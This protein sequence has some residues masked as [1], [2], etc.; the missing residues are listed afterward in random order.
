[1]RIVLL[2]APGVGKGTQARVIAEAHRIPAVATGDILRAAMRDETPLG[3]QAKEFVKRGDLVP[4]DIVIGVV[5]E[6][7]AQPDAANGF[8]LD[9]FPRTIAQAEAL[10]TILA[11]R[12][13]ALDAVVAIEVPDEVIVRRLAGRLTCPECGGVYGPDEG[14]QEGGACPRCS[15]SLTVRPDDKPDA[16]R[17]RLA[18]YRESTEPLVN[19]YCERGLLKTVDGDRTRDEVAKAIEAVLA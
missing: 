8:L 7:L 15:A 19:Y 11:E 12:D 5:A 1:M 3:K 18:V 2:G 17:N 14:L 9:G 6:R 10:A 16:V 4:D 13:Q